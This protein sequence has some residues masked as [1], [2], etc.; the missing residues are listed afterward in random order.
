MRGEIGI[1]VPIQVKKI[2][3]GYPQS[4]STYFKEMPWR[5]SRVLVARIWQIGISPLGQVLIF[6]TMRPI[7]LQWFKNNDTL[8]Q[9]S[10]KQSVFS[11]WRLHQNNPFVSLLNPVLAQPQEVIDKR[12]WCLSP[13]P[14]CQQ[15]PALGQWCQMV[16]HSPVVG[17]RSLSSFRS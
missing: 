3:F 17:G 8:S 16:M 10:F 9:S 4:C 6:P 5:K 2:W 13:R 15:L 7:E 1:F 12:P 14:L 11:Q